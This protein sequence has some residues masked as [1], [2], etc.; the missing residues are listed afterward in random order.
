LKRVAMPC[1][2]RAEIVIEASSQS[3]PVMKNA[4]FS[5]RGVEEYF[6]AVCSGYDNVWSGSFKAT[7]YAV[8]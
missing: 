2:A 6:G 5:V 3:P 1:A 4:K 8:V 7:P